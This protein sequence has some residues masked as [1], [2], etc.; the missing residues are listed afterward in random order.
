MFINTIE[1]TYTKASFRRL[2]A[3]DPFSRSPG[4]L[5][6]KR[7]AGF[8]FNSMIS[9]SVHTHT[10]VFRNITYFHLRISLQQHEYD[11]VRLHSLDFIGGFIDSFRYSHTFGC[12]FLAFQ[13]SFVLIILHLGAAE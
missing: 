9:D 3:H 8:Q 4:A 5:S 11:I 1:F 2:F 6:D 12:C 10:Y 13:E 7:A